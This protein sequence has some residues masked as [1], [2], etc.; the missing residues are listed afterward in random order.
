MKKCLL[1]KHN[2]EVSNS[3]E[4]HKLLTNHSQGYEDR[5]L[6]NEAKPF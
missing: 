2:D 6:M 1:N 5:T 3:P 4:N